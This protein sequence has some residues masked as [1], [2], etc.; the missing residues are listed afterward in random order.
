MIRLSFVRRLKEAL[1]ASGRRLCFC[2]LLSGYQVSAGSYETPAAPCKCQK[3]TFSSVGQSI[4]LITGRSGVRVPEGP[5]KQYNP[6]LVPIGH[7]FG[8]IVS[9]EEIE[10]W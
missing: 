6:N 3:W 7:G 9:M 2:A 1:F 4:R 8:F 10:G 5:P